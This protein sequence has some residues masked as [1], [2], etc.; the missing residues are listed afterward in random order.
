MIFGPQGSFK[1]DGASATSNEKS[2]GR[3]CRLDQVDRGNSVQRFDLPVRGESDRV[4]G[5]AH[6]G[7]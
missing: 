6:D 4:V 1:L 2:S 3:N 5:L 7:Q